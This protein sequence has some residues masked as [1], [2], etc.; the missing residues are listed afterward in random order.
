VLNHARDSSSSLLWLRDMESDRTIT[1]LATENLETLET[2]FDFDMLVVASK[3]Y[4]PAFVSFV[5]QKIKGYDNSARQT[6]P[7]RIILSR[8]AQKVWWVIW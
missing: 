4:R 5:K 6:Y 7:G 1:S 2:T 3:V 8:A